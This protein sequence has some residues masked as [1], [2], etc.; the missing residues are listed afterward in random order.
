MCGI[1]GWIDW[2][3]DL[4]NQGAMIERMIGTLSHRGPDAKGYWLS[5]RAALGHSRLI[6]IDPQGGK[7]P[8]VYEGNGHTYTITYNGEIYNFKELRAELEKLGHTFTTYSDTAVLLH[9]YIEWGAD[10]VQHLNGIFAFGLWDES[11]Q[12]LLLA[13]DHMGV[14]PL[15]YALR[16]SAILFGSE[17]KALLAHPLVKAEVD[18]EGMAEVFTLGRCTP[19]NGVFRD[20]HEVRAGHMIVFDH[21]RARTIQYWSLRSAPH[22]D[23]LEMTVEHI[24]VL[25]EDIVRRQLIA[26]V[27]VVAM[28]SGGLD[29]SGLTALAGREF[30]RE[31]KELHTYSLDFVD[32]T[33]HFRDSAFQP[34]LDAPWAQ[35]ISEHVGT[36]H[37]KIALDTPE[38]LENLLLPLHVHDLPGMGQIETSLYL[39]FKTMKQDATVA[40]SGESADEIFGGYPWF[41]DEAM[42]N[43]PTF[44]W[45][46]MTGSK[47]SASWWSA[48]M[49]EQIQPDEYV[50]CRYQEAIAEVPHLAGEDAR[51]ARIREILYLNQTRS[52][53]LL[54]N[55][56]DRMSMAV[57]LEV[58]VP[59]CD[60]RLVEYVWNIPWEMKTIDTIEK[61]I[62]RRAFT[63]VLPDDV[64]MR[65][66]SA[67][68]TS[69][70]P[71]YQR[72]IRDWTLNIVNDPN[73][74]IRPFVNGAAI[75]ATLEGST[76][77][78]PTEFAMER[79]I[80]INAWL[81]D[82]HIRVY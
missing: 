67:Y 60:Y 15:F 35:R 42:L 47:D 1:A 51:S 53:S 10:C 39:L 56:K 54:L 50:A 75:E 74:P 36:T 26:D 25:L 68:P 14:K 11:K 55:C 6:V 66:K 40:I 82:Y 57:G 63:G 9:A 49:R 20:V 4:T 22:T 77:G 23:N 72:A 16:G 21:K 30:Q 52:L 79:L 27:P 61:G 70:N 78:L 58:R 76:L 18:R 17:L 80:Q 8:M 28:L 19:G 73:A 5:P 41:H 31:G 24:R 44:P 59:F 37:H 71:T 46:A 12:Q 65:R 34:N 45:M 2:E 33:K 69:G 43:V 29:S 62:L 32:S 48:E 81:K 64:R 38:M 13:R 7:Q 3:R